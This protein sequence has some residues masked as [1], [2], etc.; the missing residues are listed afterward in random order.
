MS[1]RASAEVLLLMP[2]LTPLLCHVD[3]GIPQLT[4]YLRGRGHAVAQRDLMDALL[5]RD[6]M[7]AEVLCELAGL[8]PGPARRQLLGMLPYQ[9]YRIAMLHGE[10]NERGV[11]EATLDAAYWDL[12]QYVADT[13]RWQPGRVE[14]LAT[15]EPGDGDMRAGVTE[16]ANAMR[17]SLFLRKALAAVIHDGLINPF[18]YMPPE[19]ARAAARPPMPLL[20]ALLEEQLSPLLSS[21]LR[22]AGMTVHSTEQLVPALQIG[23]WIKARRPDVHVIL[24]G[25][26]AVAAREPVALEPVLFDFVDSVCV[27]EGEGPLEALAAGAPPEQVPGL[28]TRQRDRAV[29]A[30][31]SPPVPLEQIP[32]PVFDGMTDHVREAMVP[33]RTVR[34]CSWGRCLF[35]HH[36]SDARQAR[37]GELGREICDAQLD[38]MA[39]MLADLGATDREVQMTLADNATPPTTL[40]RVAQRL[41]E[42]SLRVGWEAMARFSG[43]FNARLCAELARG[44]CRRLYFGLETAHAGELRRLQKGIDTRLAARCLARCAGAGI[45]AFVFLLDYPSAPWDAWPKTLDFVRRHERHIAAFIPARFVLGRDCAAFADPGALELQVPEAARRSFDVFD[46]PFSPRMWQLVDD[47]EDQLDR[48]LLD[49]VAARTVPVL[50]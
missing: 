38:A 28:I 27:C 11:S 31:P 34:G 1:D 17:T 3:I 26:W 43:E 14:H 21:R 48:C 36:V 15:E 45:K 42:E 44:G 4:A 10:L 2:P 19:V 32:A 24:G 18:G 20:A 50:K 7:D 37:P 8:L 25:P 29:T 39:G 46:L 30:P 23:S 12:L 6:L 49:L 13:E 22:V 16:L 40:R 47:Y 5:Q 41:E 33:F 35:C 9:R